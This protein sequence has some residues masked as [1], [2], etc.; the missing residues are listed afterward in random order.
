MIDTY[1]I[2]TLLVFMLVTFAIFHLMKQRQDRISKNIERLID[3]LER[4]LKREI[5]NRECGDVAGNNEFKLCKSEIEDIK[6]C[7]INSPLDDC[8]NE[9]YDRIC[10]LYDKLGYEYH[11]SCK[12]KI[13]P[14]VDYT[15]SK[16]VERKKEPMEGTT[17]EC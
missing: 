7:I 11:P 5:I 6:Q 9:T 17:N 3:E 1:W 8:I 15:P 14:T 10:L 4:K 2:V 16:I 12:K 13:P